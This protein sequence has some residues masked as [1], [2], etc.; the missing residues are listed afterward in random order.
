MARLAQNRSGD[1]SQGGKAL[2]MDALGEM[3]WTTEDNNPLR[4]SLPADQ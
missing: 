3:G 1:L 2:L 4:L